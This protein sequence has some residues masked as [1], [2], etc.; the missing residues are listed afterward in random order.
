MILFKF[1]IFKKSPFLRIT[2]ERKFISLFFIFIHENFFLP[3]NLLSHLQG[4]MDF[5]ILHSKMSFQLQYSRENN[6][7]CNSP[8][9]RVHFVPRTRS[10][11]KRE[12]YNS[13]KNVAFYTDTQSDSSAS[14]I[15]NSTQDNRPSF[16]IHRGEGDA[17]LTR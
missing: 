5:L 1:P 6:I 12:S 13:M 9:K 2:E 8:E 15:T 17:I 11:S 4:T 7:L 16:S 14:L 10:L 3:K